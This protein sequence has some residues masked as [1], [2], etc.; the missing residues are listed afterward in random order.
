MTDENLFTSQVPTGLNNSDGTPGITTGTT[1]SFAVAGSVKGIRWYCTQ[2]TGGTWTVALYEVTDDVTGTLLASRV[3]SPTPTGQAWNTML[4][5]TPVAVSSSKVYRVA[6]HNDQGRY[7]STAHFFDGGD[8]IN[9]NVR[10]LGSP[11]GGLNN[12]SFTINAALSYPSTSFNSASYFVDVVYAAGTGTPFTKDYAVN[13][14]VLNAFTKDTTVNWRVLASWL[15]NYTVSWRVLAAITK[16][17]ALAWRVLAAFNQ[18]TAL[19]WRV[20]AA[21][22]TDVDVRWRVLGAWQ[23]DTAL[24]WR[25]LGLWASDT[26]LRWR[27]RSPWTK[28][29][30]LMWR[31]LTD[32][33]P[34]LLPADVVAVLAVYLEA[35]LSATFIVSS[36]G[37]PIRE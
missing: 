31:I 10:G 8:V 29:T 30:V 9:G 4:F 23:R 5:T 36:P 19:A 15:K 6:V 25:V 2:N 16:D 20:L 35:D 27:V 11:S 17:T 13:W 14:R 21:Y 33:P 26:D 18:D 28:D 1:M 32:V 3:V 37:P 24:A 12:G 7:V 22:Q 34:T